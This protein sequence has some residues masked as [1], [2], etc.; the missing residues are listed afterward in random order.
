[1]PSRLYSTLLSLVYL[2]AFIRAEVAPAGESIIFQGL[3]KFCFGTGFS[4]PEATGVPITLSRCI[5][6]STTDSSETPS[7]FW[8]VQ[9]G[10]AASGTG[11]AGQ[12]ALGSI[13]GPI[14]AGCLTV[15]GP[16]AD[17]T[18][19]T[20]AS[21]SATN[22]LQQWN[23]NGDTTITLANSDMCLDLTNG[24]TTTGNILQIWQCFP[25]NVNQQW[26]PL[27]PFPN[28][29]EETGWLPGT[30]N[31]QF[32][33]IDGEHCLTASSNADGAPVILEE[34]SFDGGD[35]GQSQNW[36]LTGGNRFGGFGAA[37]PIT[38]Y[39]GTKCLDLTNGD[40]TNG[41]VLQIWT[42]FAGNTN[43]QWSVSGNDESIS[44][45]A[46]GPDR[47]C[48]DNTNGD[49]DSGNGIQIWDCVHNDN[50][51]WF[52]TQVLSQ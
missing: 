52:A 25:G 3:N 21:C 5:I 12:I 23:V 40:V 31:I 42:C 26:I 29:F 35:N 41:N 50:Q 38:T 37:A 44:L 33:L 19:V 1:M 16:I 28:D 27:G 36:T 14:G 6:E 45:N 15:N 51:Q 4:G 8:T 32:N 2:T 43:Q 49:L 11:P 17:G 39:G 48:L 24:N 13:F 20:S 46:G 7:I 34:C 10:G 9:N 18:Q 30:T 22:T 47:K